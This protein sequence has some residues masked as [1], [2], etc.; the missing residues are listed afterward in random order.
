MLKDQDLSQTI[1]CSKSVDPGQSIPCMDEN[2]IPV[3][4]KAVF[5]G[6]TRKKEQSCNKFNAV[7]VEKEQLESLFGFKQRKQKT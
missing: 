3:I 4:E 2:K 6:I 7:E 1:N 5:G